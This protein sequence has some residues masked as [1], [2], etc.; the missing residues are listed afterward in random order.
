MEQKPD[1]AVWGARPA[2][3]D[4]SDD[5]HASGGH[6]EDLPRPTLAARYT[7]ASRVHA[8]EGRG[9][10]A[11]LAMCAADVAALQQLLRENGLDEAADVAGQLTAVGEAVLAS[12]TGLGT[13]LGGGTDARAVLEGFRQGLVATFDESVHD[14]LTDRFAPLAH[15]EHLACHAATLDDEADD[16]LAGRTPTALLADLRA[17]AGD[18]A[19]VAEVM[20]AEGDSE[21][22]LRQMWQAD[23]AGFEAYLVS[24]ALRAGDHA[25][26]TVP[27]RWELARSLGLVPAQEEA[28]FNESVA[29]WRSALTEVVSPWE[30]AALH[31]SLVPV[32]VA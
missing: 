16:L 12:L 11:V 29:A 30:A 3:S 32:P 26:C 13:T 17:T 21:G 14:V 19:S 22:A 31:A 9:R 15:L 7:G 23:L 27:L 6:T 5:D 20:L 1:D 2:A 25:L 28:G 24:T 10:S 4:G 18:C 8:A